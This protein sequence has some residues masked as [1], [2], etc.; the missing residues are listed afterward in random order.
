MMDGEQYRKSLQEMKSV[1]Y[2]NGEKVPDF[3]SHPLIRPAFNLMKKT[4]DMAQDPNID[5]ELHSLIKVKSN[6]TGVEINSF[7]NIITSPA[8]LV[9][10]LNLQRALMRYGGGCFGAR[11]IAGAVFNALWP[12]TYDVDEANEGKT[13]YHARF[14]DYVKMVQEK[15]LMVMGCITDPK[16]DRSL[17]PHKQSDPDLF[18][19]VVERRDDGIV[20]NG[21]KFQQSGA[22]LAHELVVTP[23]TAMGP[24]DSDYA[25]SFAVPAN[26]KGVTFVN[27]SACANAKF[28]AM[29]PEDIGN[30]EYGIHLSCHVLFD[31]VFIPNE[32]VFL[33]GEWEATRNLVQ[34]FSDFQRLASCSC[35]IGYIEVCMGASEAMADYNGVPHAG[36]IRD[37]LID[38]SIDAETIHGMLAGSTAMP[39]KTKSGVVVPNAVFVNVAKLYMNNAVLK[40]GQRVT[41]IGG[42][43]LITRPSNRDLNNPEIGGLLKRYHK[44]K[45][46]AKVEDRLK[47]ARLAENLSGLACITPTLSVIAA[48]PPAVN[49][50]QVRVQTDFKRNRKAAERL[51]GI[52]E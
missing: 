40:T 23:T 8:G 13:E 5:P 11:C 48:G 39:T 42:G 32:R 27:D 22:L 25:V 36:H 3:W 29:D 43:I 15:D 38:M 35:R 12:V 9:R 47:M 1:V 33:C 2:I 16:G 26:T 19:R 28:L 18:L 4:Y 52:T 37:K 6:L 34:W 17:P 49:R 31:N 45:D 50:L 14:K 24:D 46:G 41:E 51:A 7:L 30:A 20:V 44:A 10:R 21:A